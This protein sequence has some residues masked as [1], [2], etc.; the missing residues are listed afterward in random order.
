MDK[1]INEIIA[2]NGIKSN[3]LGHGVVKW[4]FNEIEI[5]RPR[6]EHCYDVVK[7]KFNLDLQELKYHQDSMRKHWMN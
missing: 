2:E 5:D 1:S 7:D 6:V 3:D 4:S